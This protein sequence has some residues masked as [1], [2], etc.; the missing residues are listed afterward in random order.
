MST[1]LDQKC[2]IYTNTAACVIEIQNALELWQDM[3]DIIKGD[4]IVITGNLKPE[5]K[6]ATIEDF[7]KQ[8]DNQQEL[9]NA[10]KFFPRILVATAGSVGGG[11][12]YSDVFVVGRSGFSTSIF[13]MAQELGRCERGRSNDTGTITDNFHLMISLEEFVYLNTRIYKP[14]PPKPLNVVPTLTKAEEI[15]LQQKELLKIIKI[16]CIEGRLLASSNKKS[17]GESNGASFN[18]CH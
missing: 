12:D 6:F 1:K 3:E 7:T 2:I 14:S 16:D 11:L 15:N 13:E 17:I 9:V 18:Q 5:F 4:I 8:I 10:N